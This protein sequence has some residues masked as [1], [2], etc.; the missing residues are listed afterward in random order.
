MKAAKLFA[1]LK[2]KPSPLMLRIVAINLLSLL[3]I[4]LFNYLA[5]YDTNNKAFIDSVTEYN[6]RVSAIALKNIDRQLMQPIAGLA[7]I[8]FADI[9]AN[10]VLIRPV[11]AQ[12]SFIPSQI[13]SLRNRVNE[14]H[15]AYPNAFGLDV[16][17]E[18]T[19]TI[20][21]GNA[22]IHFDCDEQERRR[23]LPWYGDFAASGNH[24]LIMPIAA[25]SYPNAQP[26]LTFVT[27]MRYSRLH[28]SSVVVAVHLSPRS[29]AE[30]LDE[31][32]GQLI[33]EN[34]NGDILYNTPG[35]EGEP[36]Q[37]V[38]EVSARLNGQDFDKGATLRLNETNAMVSVASTPALGLRYYH[39]VPYNIF[40][41]DYNSHL[42]L[43]IFNYL[44][45]VLFTFMVLAFI[46]LLSS[47]IYQRRLAGVSKMAGLT[48]ARGINAFD[49]SLDK[50]NSHLSLLDNEVRHSRPILHR[51]YLRSLILG[52]RSGEAYRQLLPLF[53]HPGVVC[54]LV[55]LPAHDA[56]GQELD[57][58]YSRLDA[59][60]PDYN[61]FLTTLEQ[62]RLAVVIS[63][64]QERYRE[65][66]SWLYDELEQLFPSF[67][68]A[69]G[70]WFFLSE[71][72]LKEAYDSAIEIGRYHFIYPEQR[73][74]CYPEID[75]NKMK[76]SGSHLKLFAQ[77]ERDIMSENLLDAKQKLFALSE[78]F[79]FGNYG[80]DY[81]V[82]TL[83][84]LVALLY[85]LS[86]NSKLDAWVVFGCDIR[87]YYH[88]IADID[89]FYR[90]SCDLCET[91]MQHLRQRKRSINPDLPALIVSLVEQNLEN[92]ISLEFLAD[93]LGQRPDV[94]SRT[95]RQ[96]MGQNY[97][98]YI[99]EKKLA[100]AKELI[101]QGLSMKEIA[102]RLGYN[103]AQYF[104]KIFKE[105]YG[106]TPYQYK[107]NGPPPE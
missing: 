54:V 43:L 12:P 49:S 25:H 7:T 73:K 103:S 31:Q 76:N 92:N 28:N 23:Y 107:K 6:E 78:S 105:S 11:R 90:W 63:C 80:V 71:K 41:S 69:S 82:S 9:P 88:E 95:F 29:F 104:I 79:K 5:F 51:S 61:L 97:T 57:V 50:L 86:Q 91:L 1:W 4:S 33:I 81:C 32:Q 100:R 38:E 2:E 67:Y 55:N 19:G 106:V 37:I 94:L 56:A 27:R 52:R 24:S 102:R 40:F 15:Q 26:A 16:Y 62:N 42:R 14:I 30:Y 46:T 68:S 74:L 64:E 22:N 84:D 3:I 98:D 59:Q 35:S 89:E 96:L 10:D 66:V 44:I 65:V 58:L 72:S 77:L 13:V 20:I 36:A 83:R 45:S 93:R 8:Y 21:C 87:A 60:S 34:S 17:Y 53:V 70:R 101:A 47:L 99:K 75:P 18:S 39:V 48:V 85:N